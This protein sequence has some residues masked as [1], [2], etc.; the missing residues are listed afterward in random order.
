MNGTGTQDRYVTYWHATRL[1]LNSLVFVVP[2]LLVYEIGMI[3]CGPDVM[4]NGADTWLR[5]LILSL[6]FGQYFFLPLLTCALLLAQQ[7]LSRHRWRWTPHIALLMFVE[8]ACM[9]LVLLA[10][11]HTQSA[12]AQQFSHSSVLAQLGW[13]SLHGYALFIGYCG[14]G[15]YEETLFRLLLLPLVVVAAGC[16]FSSRNVWHFSCRHHDQP[17]VCGGTLSVHVAVG[18]RIRM[19]QFRVSFCGWNVFLSAL[20]DTR[21]RSRRGHT[22]AI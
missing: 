1:P 14:A 21:F 13:P 7:H 17:G 5:H 6:G 4:R 8:S 11:S 15:I 20:P 19:V 16:C 3:L 18:R 22:H 12:L 2:I 9:A 10:W